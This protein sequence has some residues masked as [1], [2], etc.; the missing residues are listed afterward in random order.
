MG[1]IQLIGSAYSG[2]SIIASG[3][4]TVNLYGEVNASDPESPVPVSYYPTAGT[5]LYAQPN[6]LNFNKVRGEYRTSIGTAYAV[7]GQTVYVISDT[8]TLIELGTIANRPSQIYFSDNGLVCLFVDG[9]SGYVIDLVTNQLGII[10]DPNFYPADYIALIDTFFILN[11]SGTN[12]FF[13]TGSNVDFGML[14]SSSIASGTIIGGSAYTNGTYTSVPL[15]GG[16]GSGA[17]A[18]ITVAGG[19]VTVVSIDDGGVNYSL[20]DVL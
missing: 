13:I 11:R 15:T 5:D 12:Q 3:Q 2:K 19:I 8:N 16:T 6:P 4:E 20:S 17:T 18:D 14:T 7:I 1:R 10:T 9:E